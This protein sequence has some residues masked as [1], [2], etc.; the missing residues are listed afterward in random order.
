V[1]LTVMNSGRPIPKELL[2]LLFDPLVRH[3]LDDADGP[4]GSMGLGL[5]I[6]RE[7]VRAHQGTIEVT[8][9]DDGTTV[10]TIVLP[11]GGDCEEEMA[12]KEVS[13]AISEV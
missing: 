6:C 12:P 10:F 9:S 13:Q 8:S 3:S 7:V 5:Y 1:V 2:S 4:P 11:R